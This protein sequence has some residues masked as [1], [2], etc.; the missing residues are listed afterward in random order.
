MTK[1][2][3]AR[4]ELDKVV[5]RYRDYN[6]G[7]EVI[8]QAIDTLIA[9]TREDALAPRESSPE[10]EKAEMVLRAWAATPFL[11]GRAGTCSV[12]AAELDRLR[13]EVARLQSQP[14]P[15][16]AGSA[17]SA[18]E[19]CWTI[20]ETASDAIPRD[21]DCVYASAKH[22]REY[23]ERLRRLGRARILIEQD[24]TVTVTEECEHVYEVTIRA[25]RLQP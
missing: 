6:A 11:D 2:E 17:E 21:G 23:A 22:A 16:D 20:A 4:A 15:A 18:E 12:I 5:Y 3:E 13:A 24:G 14:A 8:E 1:L 9:A 19:T 25:R 10:M 7:Y